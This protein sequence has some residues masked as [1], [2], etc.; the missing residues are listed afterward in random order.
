MMGPSKILTVS[1]GTFSCT[2]EGFDDPF[3]TM[4]G[5]AEYFRDLAA[6]DRYFGAEPPTPDA[7]MLH[8]IAQ[9]EV[10]HRVEAHVDDNGVVLRQVEQADTAPHVAEAA[11][12]VTPAAVDVPP[13]TAPATT[14]PPVSP[15]TTA[16]SD[17]VAAKLA[18][19]RAV[20]AQ[21]SGYQEDEQ[22]DVFASAP[23]SAAFQDV[24][25][26]EEPESFLDAAPAEPET[27]D[28]TATPGA[29][30]AVNEDAAQ[31]DDPTHAPATSEQETGP[32]T[33]QAEDP[34][35]RIMDS[36]AEV[37]EAAADDSND[38][39]AE[40]D[41]DIDAGET[42]NMAAPGTGAIARVVKMRRA[43]FE[44]AVET[45][46]FEALGE[47]E[48]TGETGGETGT[49][50][51][52][53]DD[54]A[55]VVDDAPTTL[56]PEDEAELMANL[57][58]V[59]RKAEADLRAEKEGRVLLE[60][61]DIEASADSV[62]RILEVT[63]TE[64]EETEGTRRRSA[65]AHLKA[66]VAATRA[67]KFLSKKREED[68][69]NEM[70]QYRQDLAKVVRPRRPS[71]SATPKERRTAPLVLVSEQRVDSPQPEPTGDG[72]VVRPRRV[73]AG[74]LAL[75]TADMVSSGAAA[76]ENIFL[77]AG[78]FAAF[79]AEMGA[80]ELPDLLEAAAAYSAF[81]E[82]NE[83]FSRPQIMKTV[84]E[85]D[86]ERTYTREESLR[87]F[88]LLLRRGKIKKLKRG[89]FIIAET[90]RF[91]P[92]QRAVGE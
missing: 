47:D 28:S 12:A 39:S 78:S 13:Q 75:S 35:T 62:S 1:Y 32:E 60:K 26:A 9:R 41:D 34:I 73:T 2:L 23:I 42:P 40:A 29:D 22:Q 30:I 89:Q 92:Q 17:S 84:A 70:N 85:M 8:R 90:T 83:H 16:D 81:I 53:F 49:E 67:D 43:D 36:V 71:E 19:I 48:T 57:E 80:R 46:D 59:Q 50:N 25:E 63:N 54:D 33:A 65:I 3:S 37:D 61:Q 82:G 72:A 45:G 91:N 44:A 10:Q 11:P 55:D 6:D 69:A 52:D 38:D 77:E 79:A 74:S 18:R 58:Q 88:G 7:E 24:S 21:D 5:I 87:S 20:V 4:R 56:S 15:S 31:S 64:M 68:D 76:Q 27:P 51:G 66:A 86:E 14:P